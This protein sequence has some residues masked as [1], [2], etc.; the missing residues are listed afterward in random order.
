MTNKFIKTWA[1]ILKESDEEDIS[2]ADNLENENTVYSLEDI[3]NLIKSG[4]YVSYFNLNKN[5]FNI[6]DL[7]KIF[8]DYVLIEM[9]SFKS[10]GKYKCIGSRINEL[11]YD[12]YDEKVYMGG[13][14]RNVDDLFDLY[15]EEIVDKNHPEIIP[16]DEYI[17][18]ERELKK[19]FFFIKKSDLENISNIIKDKDILTK[20]A[21]FC[22]TSKDDRNAV[23]Y[24]KYEIYTGFTV[25]IDDPDEG[26]EFSIIYLNSDVS[27]EINKVV[28]ELAAKNSKIKD[29]F[30]EIIWEIFEKKIFET[31]YDLIK[32][33]VE[34][35]LEP[36]YDESAYEEQQREKYRRIEDPFYY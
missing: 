24:N 32:K 19:S 14:V 8:D 18:A 28:T 5:V 34:Y 30:F 1:K 21:F 12:I 4:E 31:Q 20:K 27:D 22:D 16:S 2:S 13:K 9:D 33:R 35:E 6:D 11:T 15:T 23:F 7:Q 17:D 3:S 25:Y 36:D 29:K 26:G 10:E